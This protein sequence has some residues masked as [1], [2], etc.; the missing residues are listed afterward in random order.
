[1]VD[2]DGDQDFI[3]SSDT[4][5]SLSYLLND[6]SGTF[7]APVTI[8]DQIQRVSHAISADINGN[9]VLDIVAASYDDNQIAWFENLG[10]FTNTITG[11]V[12]V[13]LDNNDCGANSV[14]AANVF[15]TTTNSTNSFSTFTQSDGSFSFLANQELFTTDILAALPG[16]YTSNPLQHT[17]D[18][19]D[20]TG[21]NENIAFCVQAN[22]AVQDLNVSLY[23]TDEPRPGL[24]SEYLLADKN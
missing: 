5:K 6:G 18:F 15:V 8:Y 20:L 9:G 21:S 1:D 3:A 22:Q 14:P 12:Q 11:V 7:E 23:S 2:G 16:H 19:T 10:N 4:A 24:E 17:S 13:D